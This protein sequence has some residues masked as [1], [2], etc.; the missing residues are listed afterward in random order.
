VDLVTLKFDVSKACPIPWK[1]P[2]LHPFVARKGEINHGDILGV[3]QANNPDAASAASNGK[4]FGVFR[5]ADQL[6]S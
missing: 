6:P 5:A 4:K 1:G 2:C 3:G